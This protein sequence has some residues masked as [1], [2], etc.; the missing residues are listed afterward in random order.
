MPTIIPREDGKG[1]AYPYAYNVNDELISVDSAVKIINGQKE[2]YYLFKGLSCELVLVHG[3]VKVKHFRTKPDSFIR[4]ADGK[5][6]PYQL[7]GESEA[8]IREKQKI[9]FNEC[10]YW[11][12]HKIPIRNARIESKLFGSSYYADCRAELLDGTP[13]VIEVILSSETSDD[14]KEFLKQAKI[15]TF[16]IHIDRNGNTINNRFSIYGN[17]QIEQIQTEIA[18]IDR[19]ILAGKEEYQRIKRK[20]TEVEGQYRIEKGQINERIKSMESDIQQ[21]IDGKES[22]LRGISAPG[23]FNS[24]QLYRKTQEVIYKLREIRREIKA[25]E[26][27]NERIIQLRDEIKGLEIECKTLENTFIQASKGCKLEWYAGGFAKELHGENRLHQLIY[28][29]S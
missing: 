15:L 24:F 21:E 22:L 23:E 3:D 13:C 8:H 28:W 2:K 19:R 14:K 12:G 7:C 9:A 18:N 27:G 5:N 17:G 16:E 4:T 1:L 25:T 11:Q 20:A 10:F 26:K 6:I 29:C